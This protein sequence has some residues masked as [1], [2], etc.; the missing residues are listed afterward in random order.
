MLIGLATALFALLA[1]TLAAWF[2]IT[3]IMNLTF[4][5]EPIVLFTTVGIALILTIGMGLAGTYR[6][7]GQKASP[8]LRSL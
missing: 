5:F 6:I 4:S 3:N 1:G 7:L 2:V 8:V